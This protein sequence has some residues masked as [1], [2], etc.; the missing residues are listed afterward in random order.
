MD[1]IILN[2]NYRLETLAEIEVDLHRFIKSTMSFSQAELAV[3]LHQQQDQANKN[4]P[5]A[6]RQAIEAALHTL[7]VRGFLHPYVPLWSPSMLLW[8][9]WLPVIIGLALSFGTL[10]AWLAAW[11][12]RSLIE[13][14]AIA[15]VLLPIWLVYGHRVTDAP[16]SY[17]VRQLRKTLGDPEFRA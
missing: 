10:P 5:R 3:E 17:R 9:I 7:E 15:V 8:V 2:P 4:D 14:M 13:S 6:Y 11:R 16:F 12:T 1:L